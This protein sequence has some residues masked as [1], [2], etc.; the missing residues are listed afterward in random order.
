M[1]LTDVFSVQTELMVDD[2]A[3]MIDMHYRR[4]SGGPAGFPAS[5]LAAIFHTAIGGPLLA[6]LATTVQM[7]RIIVRP[8]DGASGPPYEANYSDTEIGTGLGTDPMPPSIALLLK[9]RCSSPNSRNNGHLYIPGIPEAVWSNGVW[10]AAGFVPAVTT[11]R[12]AIAGNIGPSAGGCTYTPVVLSR[13]LANVKRVPP[14]TFDVTGC[15][16]RP[17]VSQQ[18]R[19]QSRK[20]GI[21]T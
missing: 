12:S 10:I 2:R 20:Q 18:R 7:M 3:C 13:Y 16:L 21:K 9:L 17:L 14:V 1:S 19:R 11:L 8:L 5:D 4:S 15:E 6:I